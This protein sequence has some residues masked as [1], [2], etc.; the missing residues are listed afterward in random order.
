[1]LWYSKK[2]VRVSMCISVWSICFC[3]YYI[4]IFSLYHLLQRN[5]YIYAHL[6]T[7]IVRRKMIFPSRR[8][9]SIN[10]VHKTF[11]GA[12]WYLWAPESRGLSF[13]R[14]GIILIVQSIAR[15][16]RYDM[17]ALALREMC[18]QGQRIKNRLASYILESMFA[19]GVSSWTKRSYTRSSI[20]PQ[21]KL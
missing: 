9:S 19:R 3:F 14:N 17:L 10:F 15:T 1:M 5:I 16:T 20:K 18:F 21:F 6:C 2:I 8:E 11:F 13:E 12:I 4:N 7:E